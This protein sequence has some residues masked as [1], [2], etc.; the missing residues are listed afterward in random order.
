MAESNKKNLTVYLDY[1]WCLYWEI[2][3]IYLYNGIEDKWEW[4]CGS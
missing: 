1:F 2:K 4:K 3:V